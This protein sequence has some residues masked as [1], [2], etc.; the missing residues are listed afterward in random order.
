MKS[1]QKGFT[2]LEI[3]ISLTIIAILTAIV[4]NSFQISSLKKQQDGIVQAIIASLEKAKSETQAGKDGNQF[5]IKFNTNDYIYFAGSSFSSGAPE[6]E[7][8]VI[9]P[10]FEITDTLSNSDSAIVFSKLLGR[11]NET[12]I[13]TI[14]HIDE[15]IPDKAFQIESTGNISIIE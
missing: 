6:N 14:S 13:I 3:V 11:P 9:S 10:Q 8:F 7:L 2:L 5:G 4:M 15:R 1:Y 12:A